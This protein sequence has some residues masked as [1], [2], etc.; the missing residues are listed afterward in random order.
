MARSSAKTKDSAYQVSASARTNT[1]AIWSLVLSIV[2]IGGIGSI[3]GIALGVKA[4]RRVSET[5]ERGRGMA[6]A[7]VI[8]GVVTL[9]LSIAY[10]AYLGTHFNVTPGHGGGFSQ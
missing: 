7:A 8:L 4:H 6:I 9:F 10:W 1:M 5:G 3:A 2:S